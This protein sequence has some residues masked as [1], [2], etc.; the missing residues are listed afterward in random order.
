MCGIAGS[1]NRERERPVEEGLLRRM[2]DAIEH[3]GPN[4]EGYY[5]DGPV[6]LCMRRLQVIDL[7]GGHFAGALGFQHDP[8][9]PF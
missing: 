9:G 7:A 5:R 6:G 1:I 4:E 2:C 8:L 3:R